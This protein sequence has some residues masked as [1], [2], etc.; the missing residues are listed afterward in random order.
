MEDSVLILRA[1]T[2]NV[3]DVIV[4][5]GTREPA[6]FSGVEGVPPEQTSRRRSMTTAAWARSM[7]PYDLK[8]P[9]LSTPVSMPIL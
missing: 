5:Q 7:T 3:E 1:V 9:L 6:G 4:G 2:L 8:V